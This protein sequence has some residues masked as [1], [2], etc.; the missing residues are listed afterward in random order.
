MWIAESSTGFSLM[1]RTRQ[2]AEL[3]NRWQA[4]GRGKKILWLL[5]GGSC[6]TL[7]ALVWWVSQPEYRVLYSALSAEESGAITSK[8]QGKG[9]NYKLAAGGSTILVAADQVMQVH[10][11]L[12]SE[13]IPG[14][15][16]LGGKGF[17]LFD[18]PS[19][20]TTSFNQHV[21]FMRAQQ[22]ELA[23][24]IMQIDPVVFARVHIVT[25]E[26]SPFMRDQ[27]PTTASVMVKLRPAANLNRSTVAGIAALVAGSVEG[28]SR[29][30]VKIIDSTGKFLSDRGDG[31]AG[32]MMGS[33]IEQRKEIEQYL[34]GEA[35]HM[36]SH[37]LGNGKAI[38]RVTAE[39]NPKE[40]HEKKE[41]IIAEGKVARTEKT[42]LKKTSGESTGKGGA[43]GAASN[44]K[45]A[46]GGGSTGGTKLEE[47][48]QSDYEYPRT[49]QEWQQKHAS[50]DRLTVAAFVDLGG[51]EEK[52]IS[53]ADISETIKKAVGFKADRDDIQITQV[54][55][56][57]ATNDEF[58]KEWAAH[59]KWQS[60][61]AIIRHASMGMIALCA[62]PLLWVILRRRPL[63]S[64]ATEPPQELPE[65]VKLRTISAEFE[66]NPEAL[67][68]I[69]SRWLERAETAEQKVA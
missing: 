2:L 68:N 65:V 35:E 59:Q 44:I 66:R 54:K 37:V 33:A 32:S 69:L 19:F 3:W 1:D 46:V 43:A 26:K 36:L 40:M 17:D 42:T 60:T 8:L 38:V 25:P 57:T 27:K 12:T 50:I 6:L 23:R 63:A 16:K 9:V 41:M 5:V 13:G 67:A 21:N 14:T 11:D 61:L 34:A 51:S 28:L 20:G 62:V 18:Q 22:T 39:L 29:E 56:P 45:L 52:A 55:M 49:V 31:E 30:N 4:L 24:T 47:T 48:Q 7:A 58:E 10:V 15:S 64:P 53:L